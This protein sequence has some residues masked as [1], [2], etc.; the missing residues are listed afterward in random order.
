MRTRTRL[1]PIPALALALCLAAPAAAKTVPL[2]PYVDMAGYPPPALAKSSQ[3]SGVKRITLG[4]ITARSGSDCV[5]TWGGYPEYG[6]AYRK[7]DVAAFQRQ[8]GVATVSFGGQAGTEL[9]TAC[10]SVAALATAYQDVVD[11]YRVHRVDFDIEGAAVQ[12]T[13]ATA[14]RRAAVAK[15]H[16]V[17]VSYTLPVLPSGLDAAG[18][19]LAKGAD[20][21]N[22]MAMDYGDQFKGD[23][24]AY[25]IAAARATKRQLKLPYR[26]LSV[27]P[28]LGINDVSSEIFSL[29]DARQLRRWAHSHGLGGLGMWQLGRDAPCK[30]PS[31]TTQLD[32]SG[33]PQQPYAF[34]RALR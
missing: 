30:T 21:V 11:A 16:G 28:M 31:K 2:S 7:A 3:A 22:I 8:G 5:P 32:C 13:A 17:T 14:R 23:M 34:S 19:A 18:R 25:A 15:L 12:D 20:L 9:A 26:R 24:G 33:V 1:N 29:A 10:D 6:T 27:T 4:F